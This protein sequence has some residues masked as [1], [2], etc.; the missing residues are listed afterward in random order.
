MFKKREYERA[1]QI[2][3]ENGLDIAETEFRPDGSIRLV[4]VAVNKP[5]SA[6]DD[7]RN[8]R[9]GKAT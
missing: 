8:K 6:L 2:A 1:V 9:D 3:R 4:H 5:Q 7:W